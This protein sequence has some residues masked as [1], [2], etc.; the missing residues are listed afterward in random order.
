MPSS[1]RM[2]FLYTQDMKVLAKAKQASMKQVLK[3]EVADV[4]KHVS[5]VAQPIQ[6]VN[7]PTFRRATART[8]NSADEDTC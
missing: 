4:S 6:T 7:T 3:V 5:C 2:P 8:K 1:A